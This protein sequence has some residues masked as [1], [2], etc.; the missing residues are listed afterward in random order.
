MKCCTL[1][2]G[3]LRARF[4]FGDE[5]AAGTFRVQAEHDLYRIVHLDGVLCSIINVLHAL[6][7]STGGTLSF[8]KIGAA[9]TSSDEFQFAKFIFVCMYRYLIDDCARI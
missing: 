7:A 6:T 2:A 9:R 3:K 5:P 8:F 1:K 4:F